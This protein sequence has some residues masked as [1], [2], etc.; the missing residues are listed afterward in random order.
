MNRLESFPVPVNEEDF[1]SKALDLFR[2]QVS[3]PGLYADFV[4]ALGIE[5]GDVRR[6][7]E[8][9]FLPISFFRSHRIYLGNSDPELIFR[10]SR[11]GSTIPSTHYIA[12]A[13]V[14]RQSLAEG[15]RFFFGEPEDYHFYF[16]LPSYLER[17][18]SSLVFMARELLK[19]NGQKDSFY[20]DNYEALRDELYRARNASRKIMLLGVSFALLDMAEHFPFSIPELMVVETGGMKG[21]GREPVREELHAAIRKGMGVQHVYSEYGMTELLSQ[22]WS[23]R[24][25]CFRC[26]PWMD[27]RIFDQQD[28][29]SGLTA[30]ET[31]LAGICDLAN[32]WSCAFVQS[33]DLARKLA[34]GS[35][36]I[37]GR[38]DNSEIR[39][40]SLMLSR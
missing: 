2:F 4:R 18:D 27:I 11:T 23:V 29:L 26:P 35:Y 39:G 9:P 8:I 40:C 3:R 7:E 28:P 25:G 16:L 33:A 34:D 19:L 5:A 15:F 14:Y 22:A 17:D 12:S 6:Y 10:S 31:G 38:A 37:L 1:K 30:G 24:D 13:E 21:R 32:R 20:L 36:E